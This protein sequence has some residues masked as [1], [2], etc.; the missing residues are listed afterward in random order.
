LGRYQGNNP[1][2]SRPH[3]FPLRGQQIINRFPEG[4]RVTTPTG[5]YLLWVEMPETV[6]ALVLYRMALQAGISLVPGHLF[7]A[8]SQFHN[9]VRLSAAHWSEKTESA[10][11]HLGEMA[12]QLAETASPIPAPIQV[13][14]RFSDGQPPT[15][16]S[17][18]QSS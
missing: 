8:S 9:C 15:G 18:T 4:T 16:L 14:P 11:S 17:I 3:L 6:N 5:G 13:R 7:S 10:L 12:R 2:G 1:Q